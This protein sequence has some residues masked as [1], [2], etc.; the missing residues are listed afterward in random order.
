MKGI[1]SVSEMFLLNHL[2]TFQ[3]YI[4]RFRKM[5]FKVA[6]ATCGHVLG[7]QM[8]VCPNLVRHVSR[9]IVFVTFFY[10]RLSL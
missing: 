3:L 2:Q 9:H 7:F 8:S 6:E 10:Q 1:L 4:V 5:I